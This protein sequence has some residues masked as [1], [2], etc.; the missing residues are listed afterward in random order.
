MTRNKGSAHGRN[1]THGVWSERVIVGFCRPSCCKTPTG[2]SVVRDEFQPPD[3]RAC[4]CHTTDDK[5]AA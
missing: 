4:Y 2:H 3:P 1:V 5:D